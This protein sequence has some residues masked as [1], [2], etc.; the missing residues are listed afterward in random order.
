MLTDNHRNK[1]FPRLPSDKVCNIWTDPTHDLATDTYAS[2]AHFTGR[3]GL[4]YTDWLKSNPII[5]MLFNKL[6]KNF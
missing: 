2:K 6:L 4:L 3:S 1:T 5:K